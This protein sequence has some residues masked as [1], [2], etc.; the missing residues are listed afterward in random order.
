MPLVQ[1]ENLVNIL[2]QHMPSFFWRS[3]DLLAIGSCK[4]TAALEYSDSWSV[5]QFYTMPSTLLWLRDGYDL[6]TE[7]EGTST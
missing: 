3:Q 1:L 4:C 6:S 5:Q 2:G 7:D